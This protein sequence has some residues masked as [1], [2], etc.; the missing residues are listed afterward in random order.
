V[1]LEEETAMEKPVRGRRRGPLVQ[2]EKGCWS[3]TGGTL[4]PQEGSHYS[5][6]RALST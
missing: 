4:E 2:E 6:K 5:Q 1:K 3:T